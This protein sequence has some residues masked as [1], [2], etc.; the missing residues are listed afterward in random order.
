MTAGWLVR[1]VEAADV[2]YLNVVRRSA[3]DF[4]SIQAEKYAETI[5]LAIEALGI[6]GP[7]AM[8]VKERKEIAAGIYTLQVSRLGRKGS[9][10]LVFRVV[11]E[12]AVEIIRILHEKMD[13]ERNI[14]WEPP[15]H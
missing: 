5:A 11:D 12:S 3:Q 1:L 13:L 6:D 10:F 8:G 7:K 14:S 4:G 2:D 15:Q 9:H